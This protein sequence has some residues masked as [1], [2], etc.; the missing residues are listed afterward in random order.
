MKTAREKCVADA[1]I[2]AV[3]GCIARRRADARVA[4]HR[5]IRAKIPLLEIYG[6]VKARIEGMRGVPDSDALQTP[7]VPTLEELRDKWLPEYLSGS[8]NGVVTKDVLELNIVVPAV[9]KAH[10]R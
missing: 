4:K 10:S 2:E 8:T 5:N 3:S 6:S 7:E 1:V 9:R